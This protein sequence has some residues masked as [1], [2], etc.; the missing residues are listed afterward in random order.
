MGND[1]Y[2]TVHVTGFVNTSN[3]PTLKIHNIRLVNVTNLKFG[4]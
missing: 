2:C 4:Q 3:L 1:T